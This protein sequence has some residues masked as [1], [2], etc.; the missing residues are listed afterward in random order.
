M[1]ILSFK[2]AAKLGYT[3]EDSHPIYFAGDNEVIALKQE[4]KA[5][6][7]AKASRSEISSILRSASVSKDCA[8]WMRIF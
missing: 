4:E 3:I 7:L 6:R 1:V 2:L 5:L 8:N